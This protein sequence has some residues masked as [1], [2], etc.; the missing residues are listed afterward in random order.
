[1]TN[2]DAVTA[3]TYKVFPTYLLCQI[4]VIYGAQ[5]SDGLDQ[6]ECM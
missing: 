4:G 2:I 3:K 6:I 5:T 1:M